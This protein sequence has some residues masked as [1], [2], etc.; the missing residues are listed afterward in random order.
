MPNL[1]VVVSHTVKD[2]DH[3]KRVFDSHQQARKA[4]GVLGHHLNRGV[5]DP[6]M[7]H[8][9]MPITDRAR[10]EAFVA[11]PDLQATM[12]RAGVTAAPSVTWL[13]RIEGS[14]VGDRAV[15]AA[16]I[17]H[18]VADFD[19]WKAVYDEADALR[20]QAGIIGHAVNRIVGA[21]QKVLVYH[22]AENRAALQAFFGSADLKATMARAGVASPPQFN[23]VQSLP[24]AIY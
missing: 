9:F 3:W 13:E 11:D 24:G 10:F 1:A 20:A 12:S 19:A 16:M 4:A 15:A 23:H 22:Q 21:P 18:D 8:V 5:D 7:V 6:N 2:Y 14:Y 17:A